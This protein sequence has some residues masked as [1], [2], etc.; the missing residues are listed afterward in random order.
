MFAQGKIGFVISGGWLLKNIQINYLDLNFGMTLMPK[1][2]KNRGIPAS[3]AG[4]E[5]LVINKKSKHKSEAIRF[6]KFLIQKQNCLKVCQAIGSALPSA[7][8]SYYK[9]DEKLSVFQEQLKYAISPPAHPKWVYIEEIIEKK[10]EQVMYDKKTVGNALDEAKE[11][12]E[13][14]LK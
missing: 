14:H 11:E 8:G 13:K 10:I 12:I 2:S 9:E 5:F 1:P 6:I 3:F 7:K 4:G